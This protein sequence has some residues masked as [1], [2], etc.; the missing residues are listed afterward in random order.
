MYSKRKMC[1]H[2]W[3]RNKNKTV[4]KRLTMT[5]GPDAYITLSKQNHQLPG[6]LLISILRSM[7]DVRFIQ[8]TGDIFLHS[9]RKFASQN[10]HM[11]FIKGK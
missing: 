8:A 5:L 9:I 2:T 7:G 6:K 4:N 10:T 1:S 11:G 3:R